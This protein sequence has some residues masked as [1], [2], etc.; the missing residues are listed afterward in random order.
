[1]PGREH[2]RDIHVCVHVCVC[3]KS[4]ATVR[5]NPTHLFGIKVE[6]LHIIDCA[7]GHAHNVNR[8]Q[9]IL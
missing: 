6:L 1:M 8:S 5:A 4:E 2:E 7:A 3:Y 9:R